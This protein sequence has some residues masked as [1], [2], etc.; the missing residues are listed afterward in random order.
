MTDFDVAS[1]VTTLE[2]LGVKL[3]AVPLADGRLTVTRWKLPSAVEHAQEIERLWV[4][5][6]GL[7]GARMDLLARHI[8]QLA[9]A[10]SVL[11]SGDTRR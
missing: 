10:T 7:S 1:F 6:V 4:S 2:S 5:Q 3:A 11:T 8:S 9:P